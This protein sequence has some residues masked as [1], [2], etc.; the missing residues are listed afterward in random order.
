VLDLLGAIICPHD[1]LGALYRHSRLLY[2]VLGARLLGVSTPEC[3]YSLWNLLLVLAVLRISWEF[4][5][6]PGSTSFLLRFSFLRSAV[7]AVARR[8]LR[9]SR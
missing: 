5:H 1:I 8:H 6:P 3:Y 4:L 9:A 2:Y 7:R